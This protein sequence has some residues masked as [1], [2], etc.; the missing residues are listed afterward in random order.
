MRR[1][2]IQLLPACIPRRRRRRNDKLQFRLRFSKLLNQRPR[3]IDLPD[4]HRMNPNRLRIG[5]PPRLHAPSA[6]SAPAAPSPSPIFNQP[7]RR[8]RPEPHPVCN[9]VKVEHAIRS[10]VKP[11]L[12]DISFHNPRHQFPNPFASAHAA[13]DFGGADIHQRRFHDTFA[14]R[15]VRFGQ[16]RPLKL[17]SRSRHDHKTHFLN[18][19]PRFLPI[20]QIIEHI[21]PDQ[22]VDPP[23]PSPLQLLHRL[24][25]ITW[26]TPPHLKVIHRKQRS[27]PA[28]AR[29]IAK[30]C[31]APAKSA[32]PSLCGGCPLGINNTRSNPF[33]FAT[34][35]AKQ[36]AIMNWVET[37]AK[38]EG[39]HYDVLGA[40]YLRKTPVE[41]G[42]L[43]IAITLGVVTELQ[44]MSSSNCCFNPFE[45]GYKPLIHRIL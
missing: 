32:A 39:T 19:F 23:K 5:L 3:R 4:A 7:I 8:R 2:P 41:M 17:K 34:A 37:S 18:Q 33:S 24:D 15:L 43:D 25:R 35:R 6:P 40:L 45:N 27:S 22:P 38:A 12:P 42:G 20:R 11:M 14:Q 13:A 1:L 26:P 29:H 30:R 16:R 44:L 28:T 31:S 9:I 10:K 21:R 36:V